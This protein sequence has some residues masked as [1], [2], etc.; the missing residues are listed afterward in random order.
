M[1]HSRWNAILPALSVGSAVWVRAA[2]RARA[3]AWVDRLDEPMAIPS[4]TA[5]SH[6][7]AAK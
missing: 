4:A 2:A 7:P 6:Q 1:G 3:I 5:T